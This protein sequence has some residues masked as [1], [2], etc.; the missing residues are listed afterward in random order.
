MY[1]NY[2]KH[3]LFA[4]N[5]SLTLTWDVFKLFSFRI[6]SIIIFSLTLTWDVFKLN[7]INLIGLTVI[8]LTLTWD[9]F[10]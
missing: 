9:V 4:E 7:T 2:T 1:L 8:C 10:K 5:G 6:F 3:T